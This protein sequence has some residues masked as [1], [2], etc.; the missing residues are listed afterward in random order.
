M[1]ISNYLNL[2]LDYKMCTESTSK[3]DSISM[4]ILLNNWL[5]IWKTCRKTNYVNLSMTNMEIMYNEMSC[6]DLEEVRMNRMIRQKENRG[7][8]AI[9]E[10]CE[11]LNDQSTNQVFIIIP[12]PPVNDTVSPIIPSSRSMFCTFGCTLSC[13]SIALK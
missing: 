13:A 1:T 9:D 6:A 11:M 4:E 5:P 10:A 3:G 7:M 8:I 2:C 12:S